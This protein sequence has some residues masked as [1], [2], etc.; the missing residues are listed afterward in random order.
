MGNPIPLETCMTK[1]LEQMTEQGLDYVFC[2]KKSPCVTFSDIE[3]Q[4]MTTEKYINEP[5]AFSESKNR[6][7]SQLSDHS[8]IS[9]LINFVN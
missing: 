7:Y 1:P 6:D 8:G 5:N 9:Y 3:L 4:H 2:L